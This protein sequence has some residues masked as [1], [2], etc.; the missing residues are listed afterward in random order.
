MAESNRGSSAGSASRERV[1]AVVDDD[2]RVCG[3]LEGMLEA[4]GYTT[5][6]FSSAEDFLRSASLNESTCL[7]VDVRLP[8]MDGLELQRRLNVVRPAMHIILI[9]GHP[10]ES[11]KRRGL[12]QGAICFLQKPFDPDE[13]LVAV[14]R[15]LI[16]RPGDC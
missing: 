13:L 11:S 1:V 16:E 5:A 10:D 3:S 6:V 9:T 7:I 14:D 12:E 4:A 8:L 15:A 2:A